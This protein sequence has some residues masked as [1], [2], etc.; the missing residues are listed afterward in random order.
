[1]VNVAVPRSL[2]E[3]IAI[4]SDFRDSTTT[5]NLGVDMGDIE[6]KWAFELTGINTVVAHP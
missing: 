1:M 5:V 2:V 6:D 4:A 3:R